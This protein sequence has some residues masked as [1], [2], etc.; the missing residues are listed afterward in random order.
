MD[1][2]VNRFFIKVVPDRRYLLLN[3]ANLLCQ[4]NGEAPV[5]DIVN[6]NVT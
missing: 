4:P 3:H 6:F 5:V 2:A 1:F